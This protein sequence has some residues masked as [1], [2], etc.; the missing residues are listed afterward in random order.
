M[1]Y[2]ILLIGPGDDQLRLRH[3]FDWIGGKARLRPSHHDELR[4]S[5]VV[6]RSSPW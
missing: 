6:A 2:H 3:I 5:D 1:R 4:A